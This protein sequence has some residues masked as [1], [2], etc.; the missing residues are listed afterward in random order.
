M[1]DKEKILKKLLEEKKITFEEMLILQQKETVTVT[2][3]VEKDN[4][5]IQPNTPYQPYIG[6]PDWTV[7][8]ENLPRYNHTVYPS[9]HITIL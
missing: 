9:N 2:I 3:Y 8:P 5:W 4:H 6:S 7:R 1:T